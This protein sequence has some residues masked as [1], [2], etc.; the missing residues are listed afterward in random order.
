V[1]ARL[2]PGLKP[3]AVFEAVCRQG[4]ELAPE[5]KGGATLYG[6]LVREV[7]AVYEELTRRLNASLF[8]GKEQGR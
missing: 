1:Q 8:A 2:G 3:R 5:E 6:E 7:P 4:L